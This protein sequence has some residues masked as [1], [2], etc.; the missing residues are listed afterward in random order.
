MSTIRCLLSYHKKKVND[1]PVF[2]TGVRD[3][4]YRNPDIFSTPP[5]DETEFNKLISNYNNARGAYEQGGLAQ[6]GPYLEAR[7]K[8][9]AGLDTMSDYVNT[10][11][12][13]SE[14]II[15]QS[16]FVPSKGNRSE[17]PRPLQ[18]TG[19]SVKRGTASG[20]LLAECAN[21]DVAINYGCIMTV[22]QP[23][24]S[25]VKLN[26]GGQLV[27]SDGGTA[28]LSSKEALSTSSLSG[29]L[30]LNPGR[31]KRFENLTPGTVYYFV[32]YAANASGVSEFSNSV[33][34]MCT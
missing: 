9:L 14:S 10:V 5:I 6:K 8:L 27:F 24:P 33:S 34:I 21:Q 26:S 30:D 20:V 2:A 15:L 22:G 13:G 25:N 16:G 28:P 17:A 4:V 23:L 1:L 12:Q 7:I 11:A 18:P 32:F 3:G 19:V 31:R 29:I